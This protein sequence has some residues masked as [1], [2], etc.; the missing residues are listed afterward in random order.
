MVCAVAFLDAK[1]DRTRRRG[2]ARGAT[3]EKTIR[4]NDEAWRA[5]PIA[6]LGDYY[7]AAFKL[8]R[9]TGVQHWLVLHRISDLR[10]AGDE[11]TRQQRLA[12]GLLADASTTIVYRQHAQETPAHHRALG[13]SPTERQLIG[14]LDQGVALW[15]VGGRSF[16]VHH[17]LSDL[18]WE[19][20][21]TDEAMGRDAT[22]PDRGSAQAVIRTRTRR[23]RLARSSLCAPRWPRCSSCSRCIASALAGLRRDAAH[24]IWIGPARGGLAPRAAVSH[25]SD[26]ALAWPAADRA[27]S[28]RRRAAGR[29]ADLA[30]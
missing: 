3:L 30:S 28:R 27:S 7:Q 17:V 18:E 6:G 20:I 9:K 16:Q 5:L 24:P 26:P 19:L 25:L 12:E 11:G 8:S 21:D 29:A 1:R 13:L 14:S 4:I 23:P 15:R 22:T 2:H 10:A